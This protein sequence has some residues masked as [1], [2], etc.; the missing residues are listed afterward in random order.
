MATVTFQGN[1]V[2]TVGSLPEVGQQAP[3]FTLVKADLGEVTLADL[4]GKRVILN[5]FPSVDTGTCATSVR[6]FNEQ[7]AGLDNTQV[8]CVSADL[9]FAAGR[10]C[11]AE[12]IENV[13]TGST[14][15]TSFGDDYGVAFTSMP[16]T[17]LL[18]R[19]VVV[20][21]TDGKVLYTEQVAET[22]EEPNYDSAM[23]AL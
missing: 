15:R 11:G 12:G 19:T 23:A 5:I 17:G 16:L 9:P 10:F 1:S 21:D 2:S 3:D 18:S 22:T 7:A 14:F 20:I 6:K 13:I 8:I 4:K